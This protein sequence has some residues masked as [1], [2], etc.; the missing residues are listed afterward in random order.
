MIVLKARPPVGGAQEGLKSTGQVHK[1]ITHQ[2]EPRRQ[3]HIKTHCICQKIHKTAFTNNQES[4]VKI[5][6]QEGK[7]NNEQ[8]V[9]RGFESL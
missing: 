9:V 5:G 8:E 4:K 2:E 7:G 3:I 6:E 1:Q